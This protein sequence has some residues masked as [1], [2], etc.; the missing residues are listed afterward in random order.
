MLQVNEVSTKCECEAAPGVGLPL[1]EFA[2]FCPSDSWL[3][4]TSGK[5]FECRQVKTGEKEESKIRVPKF[6]QCI[7][8]SVTIQLRISNMIQAQVTP[9]PQW[10][11]SGCSVP[12]L[13]GGPRTSRY[14]V[15]L[16][17]CIYIY[18]IMLHEPSDI[19]NEASVAH[20]LVTQCFNEYVTDS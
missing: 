4:G 16:P 2:L 10:D 12:P 17:I 19:C 11:V 8:N 18:T 14:Q 13:A 20:A 15:K 1:D 9:Q 5:S 6:Y 7:Y 3:L